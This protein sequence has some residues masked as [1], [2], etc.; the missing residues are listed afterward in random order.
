MFLSDCFIYF[1]DEQLLIFM[2]KT[3][4]P[5]TWKKRGSFLNSEETEA[6]FNFETN[7][8]SS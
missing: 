1:L 6:C 5:G 8:S 3:L 7:F 4:W 2:L